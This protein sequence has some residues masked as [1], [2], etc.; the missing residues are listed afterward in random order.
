MQTLGEKIS[1][2]SWGECTVN[3]ERLWLPPE[4][5]N[6]SSAGQLQTQEHFQAF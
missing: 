3:I 4:L 5:K 2:F 6:I 1:E